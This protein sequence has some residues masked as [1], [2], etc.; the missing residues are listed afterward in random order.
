MDST[1]LKKGVSQFAAI[2]P[3]LQRV[4]PTPTEEWSASKRFVKWGTDNLYPYYLLN[5]YRSVTTLRSI[6]DGAVNYTVGDEVTID[7]LKGRMNRLGETVRDLVRKMAFDYWLFGG[8]ALQVIRSNDNKIAELYHLPMQYL[9]WDKE[10]EVYTYS[11]K[12]DEQFGRAYKVT[13]YPKFVPKFTDKSSV[14]VKMNTHLGVYPEAMYLAAVRA[15]EIERSIDEYHLNSIENGFL[16][17]YIFQFNNGRPSDEVMAEMER[18]I[19]EKFGGSANAGR[20][21]MVFNEDETTGLKVE[22]VEQPDFADRYNSLASHCRQQIFSAFHANPNL[23]GIP[24][25]S[26]GF[27]NEEYEASFKLF[28]RTMIQPVQDMI[29]DSFG[30]IFGNRAKVAIKP[31][32]IEKDTTE[33]VE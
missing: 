5:L 22:R 32:S 25:E 8:Y 15:C 9:R 28:N 3:T 23:F 2:S 16:G 19:N 31:F 1:T 14:Y 24:T 29:V 33:I 4:I 12:W 6:V 18:N 20:I 17:S 10:G 30:F 7:K 13:E 27:N 26:L 11:E 21:M